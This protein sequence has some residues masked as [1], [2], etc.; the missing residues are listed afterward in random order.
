MTAAF[1]G[2]FVALFVAL[3]MT[4]ALAMGAWPFE[5]SYTIL[6]WSEQKQRYEECP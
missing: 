4:L 5:P 3:W 6:C 2:V 1:A